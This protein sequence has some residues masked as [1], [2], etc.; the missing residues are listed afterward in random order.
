MK[1]AILLVIRFSILSSQTFVS[2]LDVAA[3]T[4]LHIDTFEAHSLFK[5]IGLYAKEG[6]RN[7]K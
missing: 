1:D 4:N 5:T 2:C 7:T 3:C 6:I